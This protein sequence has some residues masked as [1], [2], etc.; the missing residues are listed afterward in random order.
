MVAP[1]P[2]ALMITPL[3]DIPAQ[4][5]RLR[6]SAKALRDGLETDDRLEWD[7]AITGQ[8]LGLPELANHPGP[9]AGFWPLGSEA[10]A[11]QILV[12]L[13]QRGV[14]TAL[15]AVVKGHLVF[16][17]WKPWDVIGPGGFGTLVPLDHAGEV[18]PGA[19]IVPLL[20]FDLD[21]FRIGYGKGY[22]DRAIADLSTAGQLLTIGIAYACQQV[23]MVPREPHDRRLD[24]IVTEKTVHRAN[25]RSA[26]D[27][28]T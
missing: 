4:K 2:S 1:Q 8:V 11:R 15:P 20:A 28:L 5:Q 7:E 23:A 24:V 13:A 19:L 25:A 18:R 21:G 26:R 9:V 22:Y 12:G 3:D 6:A 16:R 17:A 10:D 27:P 14:A